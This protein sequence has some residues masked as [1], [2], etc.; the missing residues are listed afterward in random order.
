MEYFGDNEEFSGRI[1]WQF[2]PGK[3]MSAH[4]SEIL[5]STKRCNKA[6]QRRRRHNQLLTYNFAH[7]TTT[8]TQYRGSVILCIWRNILVI[9]SHESP[10]PEKNLPEHK[11]FIIGDEGGDMF[12]VD[13]G[14]ICISRRVRGGY[15][16]KLYWECGGRNRR[17]G[18]STPL[19]RKKKKEIG[20][21]L[22]SKKL[23]YF[24]P[25]SLFLAR[26]RSIYYFSIIVPIPRMSIT[27]KKFMMQK[28]KMKK[29]I[30]KKYMKSLN[31]M[32]TNMMILKET[33]TMMVMM[34][35]S[36]RISTTRTNI[37]TSKKRKK[38]SWK[39]KLNRVPTPTRTR[40]PT[41]F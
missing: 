12:R 8:K 7:N 36:E 32:T 2:I 20:T 21:L 10:V 40:Q 39:R 28:T 25:S 3:S 13:R 4:N 38:R 27:T 1:G 6:F 17:N 15:W 5:K 14:C 19:F 37:E 23:T 18:K 9:Q 30:T 35:K 16:E 22:P 31:L 26:I 33:I 34:M 11:N 41:I 29:A 24:S